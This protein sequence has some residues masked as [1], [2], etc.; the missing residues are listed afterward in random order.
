LGKAV[1]ILNLDT[2]EKDRYVILGEGETD[3]DRGII[4]YLSPL[5]QALMKHQVG[6]VVEV[7]LPRG[8]AKYEILD[9]RFF[10]ET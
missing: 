6:D 5:A 8:M 7:N 2:G 10:D 1:T 3:P 4:S 9:I